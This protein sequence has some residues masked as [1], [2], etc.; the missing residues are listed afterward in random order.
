M[1]AECPARHWHFRIP[2]RLDRGSPEEKQVTAEAIAWATDLGSI[3]L[4]VFA[5]LG[6]LSA[7]VAIPRP[8]LGVLGAVAFGIASIP[9]LLIATTAGACLALLCSRHFFRDWFLRQLS[10]RP[11]A[12]AYVDAIEK[13]GWKVL[14]LL[15]LASPVPGFIQNY[16]SGLTRIPMP[17]YTIT[18]A[19]GILPGLIAFGFLGL[20][21]RS[22]IEGPQTAW[23]VVGFLT[24]SVAV[25]LIVRRAKSQM[26]QQGLAQNADR[27]YCHAFSGHHD[28]RPDFAGGE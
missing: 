27:G 28:S 25:W 10:T 9:V 26:G 14:F 20:A 12:Q 19:M 21:G 6:F 11:R 18:T 5:G 8:I 3:G 23:M 24:T 7:F 1:V 16:A 13:E 15:R 2:V 4:F 17:V 22:A